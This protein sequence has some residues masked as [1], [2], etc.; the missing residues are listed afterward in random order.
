MGKI[1]AWHAGDNNHKSDFDKIR[2][3]R[4]KKAQDE[5]GRPDVPSYVQRVAKSYALRKR[6]SKKEALDILIEESGTFETLVSR[7]SEDNKKVTKKYYKNAILGK[8]LVKKKSKF[9]PSQSQRVVDLLKSYKYVS[10]VLGGAPG[11][12][13]KA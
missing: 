5:Y 8:E 6:I 2:D 12:G 7:L 3:E 1:S 10:V 4:R 13:K 11:L 9:L